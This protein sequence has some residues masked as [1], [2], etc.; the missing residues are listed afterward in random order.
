MPGRSSH[1]VNCHGFEKQLVLSISFPI[2]VL[3][4][5]STCVLPR[6]QLRLCHAGLA[7]IYL[8]KANTPRIRWRRS[9]PRFPEIARWISEQ[10]LRLDIAAIIFPIYARLAAQSHPLRY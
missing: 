9:L 3:E 2:C 8:G 10:F 4:I 6:F 1:G 5:E 7:L